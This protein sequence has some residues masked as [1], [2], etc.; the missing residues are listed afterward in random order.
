MALGTLKKADVRNVWKHEAHDFTQWLAKEENLELLG[1]EVGI[2]ISLIATEAFAGKYKVDILAEE[3]ATNRKIIIENQLEFT[4]HK[5][6]GQ[7]IT[8]ASGYD[9]EII[10]WIV[11]GVN[12][13][14][15]QAIEWLNSV[16]NSTI[17]FFL[18]QIEIWQIDDSKYAP[19]FNVFAK[20]NEWSKMIKDNK[21]KSELKGAKLFQLEFWNGLKEYN[22]ASNTKLKFTRTPLPQHWYDISIGS[23]LCQISL[24]V[25][26]QAKQM[27]CSIYINNSKELY[28][29]FHDD[30]DAIEQ[31]IGQELKWMELPEG[32]ASKIRLFENADINNQNNWGNCFQWLNEYAEKFYTTFSSRL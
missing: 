13:E 30:K 16:T 20:P 25:N 32:K 2:D 5:H 28:K 4:D 26:S 6:L 27:A 22:N 7:I 11:N 21:V 31:E 9:A 1:E 12:D 17:N 24:T 14:H 8:Y 3:E 18:I 29:K 10:I 19:K 23:S 15:L